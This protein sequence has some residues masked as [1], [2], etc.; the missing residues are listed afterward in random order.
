MSITLY[1]SGTQ[2]ATV[3][4][5]HFLSSP[6]AVGAFRLHVD[7]SNMVAGDVLELRIYKMVLTSG[8]SRV[9]WVEQWSGPQ[10]TDALIIITDPIFNTLTDTNAVRFSLK[11]TFGTGRNFAW[12]VINENDNAVN[13]T[14]WLGT[15]CATPTVAGVPEVD[16]TQSMGFGVMAY[17]TVTAGASTTSVPTSACTP[18]GAVADQFKNRTMIFDNATTTAA[19]RSVA[20]TISAS[21]NAAAP[22]FTVATLPATPASG[23]TFVIV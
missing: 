11:Q 6:N 17:G 10:P 13:V 3:T 12:A 4:T 22:V 9:V 16:V 18:V 23:D 20:V 1:A 15:A 2:S 8:T 5:E 7:L 21:T 19:L 14:Q